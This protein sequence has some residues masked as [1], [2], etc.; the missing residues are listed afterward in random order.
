MTPKTIL[1]SK[2]GEKLYGFSILHSTLID[3][4]RVRFFPNTRTK[5]KLLCSRRVTRLAVRR[6]VGELSSSLG[7]H[8]G[9]LVAI[10]TR[11]QFILLPGSPLIHAISVSVSK[12]ILKLVL[13]II[14]E[15]ELIGVLADFENGQTLKSEKI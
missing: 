11:A 10:A 6:A 1:W 2:Q 4:P 3:V 7:V 12:L 5:Y 14:T 15:F 13:N 9:A 8:A